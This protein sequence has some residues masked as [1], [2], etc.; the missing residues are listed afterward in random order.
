M[1]A[2]F[3]ALSIPRTTVGGGAK[4]DPFALEALRQRNRLQALYERARVD[5]RGG[6]GRTPSLRDL[7]AREEADIAREHGPGAMRG[8]R[9]AIEQ[10]GAADPGKAVTFEKQQ[11]EN[12]LERSRQMAR[13]G[14]GLLDAPE[15]ARPELYRQARAWAAFNNMD[16]SKWPTEYPGDDRIKLYVNMATTLEQRLAL[17]LKDPAEIESRAE[18]EARGKAKGEAAVPGAA[19]GG[20]M[21]DR[22]VIKKLAEEGGLSPQRAAALAAGSGPRARDVATVYGKLVDDQLDDVEIMGRMARIFG[23]DWQDVMRGSAR[24]RRAR[25]RR[26]G[27]PAVAPRSRCARLPGS[28]RGRAPALSLR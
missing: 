25:S 20:R 14:R 21:L 3:P 15:Q 5:P 27:C 13:L 7:S 11:L 16:T 2:D 12:V 26:N 1:P 6:S 4:V 9:S 28:V 8:E 22:Q 24:D 10:L 17:K 18:A 23:H 19:G